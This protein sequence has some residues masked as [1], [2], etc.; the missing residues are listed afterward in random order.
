MKRITSCFIRNILVQERSFI[1][2]TFPYVIVNL[3]VHEEAVLVLFLDFKDLLLGFLIDL[4]ASR[5][6]LMYTYICIEHRLR[7]RCEN[8]LEEF[9]VD[10]HQLRMHRGVF[11]VPCQG[12]LEYESCGEDRIVVAHGIV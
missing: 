3:T 12:V 7:L 2:Q 9:L 10:A 5:R 4:D 8:H 11:F 6:I 1:E